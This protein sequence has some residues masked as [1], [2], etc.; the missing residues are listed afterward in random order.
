MASNIAATSPGCLSSSARATPPPYGRASPFVGPTSRRRRRGPGT[1]GALA[2]NTSTK[3]LIRLIPNSVN[4]TL[5]RKLGP[6]GRAAADLGLDGGKVR[7]PRWL[8]GGGAGVPGLA[9]APGLG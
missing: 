6:G 5:T 7:G 8:S 4:V 1:P 9:A 2:H 3:S